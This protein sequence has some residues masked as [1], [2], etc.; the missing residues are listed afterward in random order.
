MNEIEKV[1][2]KLNLQLFDELLMPKDFFTIENLREV[3]SYK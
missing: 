2:L 1:Y 3:T